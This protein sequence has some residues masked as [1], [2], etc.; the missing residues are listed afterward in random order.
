MGSEMCIRDRIYT[1]FVGV[2]GCLATGP[3]WTGVS[4]LKISVFS[5]FPGIGRAERVIQ[6]CESSHHCFQLAVTSRPSSVVGVVWGWGLGFSFSGLFVC[7][8]VLFID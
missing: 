7:L 1:F 2:G 8:F 6:D 4:V 3:R 5:G